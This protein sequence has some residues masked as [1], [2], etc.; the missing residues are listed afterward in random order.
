M[1][2]Q[3]KFRP[4]AGCKFWRNEIEP[5]AFNVAHAVS[6]ASPAQ[7]AG[8]ANA[9]R[10]AYRPARHFYSYFYLHAYR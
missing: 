7:N 9:C 3:K 8:T 2:S 10:P 5:D 6:H 1:V 4:R